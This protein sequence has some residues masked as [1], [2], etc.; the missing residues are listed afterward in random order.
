MHRS[1]R[2]DPRSGVSRSALLAACAGAGALL[3][4]GLALTRGDGSR[5]ADRAPTRA[6]LAAEEPAP[7]EPAAGTA[8][9]VPAAGLA[10]LEPAAAVAPAE[11]APAPAAPVTALAL[12]AGGDELEEPEGPKL[13]S[14]K[15]EGKPAKVKPRDVRQSA[16]RVLKDERVRSAERAAASGETLDAPAKT[17]RRQARRPQDDG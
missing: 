8:E 16:R 7:V 17:R 5:A 9:L 15:R 12:A 6:P 2:F 14:L 4:L 11:P 1:P 10:D 3:V 13:H